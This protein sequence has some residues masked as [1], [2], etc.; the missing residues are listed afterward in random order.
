MKVLSTPEHWF[1]VTYPQ[2]KAVVVEGIRKLVDKGVY[3][4]KLWG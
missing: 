3:P 4:E 1:G 2:D